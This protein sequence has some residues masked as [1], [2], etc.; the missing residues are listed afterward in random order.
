[1]CNG[2][3]LTLAGAPY[4]LTIGV[5]SVRGEKRASNS[6]EAPMAISLVIEI[7]R[8]QTNK[9]RVYGVSYGVASIAPRDLNG[10][11]R[12][13]G[14]RSNPPLLLTLDGGSSF[15]AVFGSVIGRPLPTVNL[16]FYRPDPT[17][18]GESQLF[19]TIIL[20]HAVISRDAWTVRSIARRSPPAE[21]RLERIESRVAPLQYGERQVE[22]IEIVYERIDWRYW[23]GPGTTADDWS[24]V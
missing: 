13:M 14:A 10:P 1:V 21:S 12:F 2:A 11:I 23:G 3:V 6:P 16:D 8:R 4:T 22:E 17:G 19:Y 9:T 7:E 24:E 15:T 18:S 20:S 5:R